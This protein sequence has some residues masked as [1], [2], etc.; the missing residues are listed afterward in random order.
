METPPLRYTPLMIDFDGLGLAAGA[1]V[2][3]DTAPLVYLVEGSAGPRR[4]VVELFMEASGSGRLR[5]AV[6]AVAWAELLAGAARNG[7]LAERYRRV[8]ADSSRIHVAPVDVAVAEEAARIVAASRVARN[9]T[10]ARPGLEL[11][12]AIHL[13]TAR[14]LGAAAALTNDEA[15]RGAAVGLR[16]FVVDE[17]AFDLA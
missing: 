15:W 4:S 3:L 6:S 14:V 5:L 9:A 8:L 2:L 1:L 10:P 12:D 11:A 17:L 7:A 13:G 16:V